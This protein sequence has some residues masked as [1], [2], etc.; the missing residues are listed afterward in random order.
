MPTANSASSS[1]KKPKGMNKKLLTHFEKRLLDER[2]RVLKELGKPE[3]L[4][5][6]V[7]SYQSM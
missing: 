2:R 5:R 4:I 3:S 7:P 1:N 6:F